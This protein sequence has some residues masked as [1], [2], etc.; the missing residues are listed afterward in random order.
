[1]YVGN[2]GGVLGKCREVVMWLLKA[3]KKAVKKAE[4]MQKLHVGHL[5]R[6]CESFLKV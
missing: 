4:M 6:L 3:I 2:S 5:A 1:M